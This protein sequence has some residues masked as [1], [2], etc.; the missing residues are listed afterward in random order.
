MWTRDKVRH[1][2]LAILGRHVQ[3]G[4][5]L[6]DDSHLVAD[7]EI[8]SL[9]VMEMVAEL[10]DRFELHIPDSALREVGT[11]SDV[12]NAVASRLARDGRFES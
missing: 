11:A 3:A 4:T 12:V 7:L 5:V 8:D 6:G 2:V 9:G 1:E 10:E